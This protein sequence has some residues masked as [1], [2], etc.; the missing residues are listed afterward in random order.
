M[1]TGQELNRS[2]LATAESVLLTPQRLSVDHYTDRQGIRGPQQLAKM[3]A[4]SGRKKAAE[5]NEVDIL[6]NEKQKAACKY[7]S[8]IISAKIERVRTHIQ[9]CPK[10]RD[11]YR[12]K[13]GALL[14]IVR[15]LFRLILEAC[16]SNVW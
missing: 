11:H 5:W 6:E 2:G 8:Q 9:K 15:I 10:R 14:K 16:N 1:V 13:A 3:P 4:D 7:C 12:E